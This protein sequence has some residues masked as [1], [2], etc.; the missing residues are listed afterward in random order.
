[1]TLNRTLAALRRARTSAIP[2]MFSYD[3]EDPDCSDPPASAR[4]M[5]LAEALA[6][7]CNMCGQCC[8]SAHADPPDGSIRSYTFGGIEQ[9]QWARLNG[10]VPLIIPLT[11]TGK[12]RAWRAADGDPATAPP[13]QCNALLPH[14]DG[15]T[16]CAIWQTRRPPPCDEYPVRASHY[17][18]ELRAG[19]YILL[20]TT[21]QRLCTWVDVLVCP[22]DSVLLDWRKADGTM[23]R[24]LAA[25]RWEYVRHVFAEAYRDSFDVG[26]RLPHSEWRAIRRTET[27]W[28]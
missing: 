10:G 15:T 24:R 17:P 23:P 5:T 12:P 6:L 20:N 25:D 8:G 4:Y 2:E 7:E 28:R 27:R 18:A 26:G 13:F 9:R 19:A 14:P 16:R 3:P 21:Y 22:D 11:L 1:M